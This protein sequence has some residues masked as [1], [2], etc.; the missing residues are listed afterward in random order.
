MWTIQ[1]NGKALKSEYSGALRLFKS[2][3]EALAHCEHIRRTWRRVPMMAL[4]RYSI[5]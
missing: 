1:I 3:Q 5:G 4:V 2:E